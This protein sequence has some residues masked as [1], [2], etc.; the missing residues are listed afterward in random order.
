MAQDMPWHYDFEDRSETYRS[1]AGSEVS[2][3]TRRY[4]GGQQSLEWSWE[5]SG[6]LVFTDPSP[7]RSEGTERVSGV[8]V[9]RG[10]T[11]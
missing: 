10:G 9:Q 8:G 11:R 2:L 6:R 7:G 5:N 3:S 1:D 4:K